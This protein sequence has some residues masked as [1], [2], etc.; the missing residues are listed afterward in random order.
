MAT[1]KKLQEQT[2]DEAL[3]SKAL[4]N[5]ARRLEMTNIE[6]AQVVGISE[7]K[8]SRMDRQEAFVSRAGKEFDLA[9]LFIRL[10]R[11]L[12]A[13][14]GGDRTTSAAWIRNANKAFNNIP[15]ERMKSLEGLVDVVHYLD[16]RRAVI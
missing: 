2:N 15:V 12:D 13:I 10:Y 6:L 8:L 3:V 11:S 14:T 7:S 4:L 5:A 9:L 16:S 1:H